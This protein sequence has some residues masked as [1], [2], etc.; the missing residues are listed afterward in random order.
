MKSYQAMLKSSMST[1]E[2]LPTHYRPTMR[3]SACFPVRYKKNKIDTIATLM[4]YWMLKRAIKEV[5]ILITIRTSDGEKILI[6]NEIVDS[7]KSYKWSAGELLPERYKITGEFLGSIEI[8]VFSSRDLVFPY[9]AITFCYAGTHGISFVHTCGRIYNDFDDIQDNSEQ[10]VPETGFDIIPHKEFKPFF[11][12]MNGPIPVKN[13]SIELCFINANGQT[14]NVSRKIE[15]VNPYGT[16][17]IDIFE[18]DKERDFLKE[19]PGS[20]KIS[21]NFQGFF[22]R[23]VAGNNFDNLSA[24]SLTHTYYDTTNDNA[25]TALWQNP[26]TKDF[27][28]S[29]MMLPINEYFDSI[30]FVVYPIFK[31]HPCTLHFD[32]FSNDGKFLFRSDEQ[33]IVA[34]GK[35]T[36][37]Y[38]DVLE[39]YKK[40][41]HNGNLALCRIVID[42]NGTTPTRM[43]F[44]LNFGKSS[45]KYKLDLPSNICESAKVPNSNILKK[46]GS[47]KWCPILDSKTQMVYITNTGFFK[48]DKLAAELKI[49]IWRENDNETLEW[50]EEIQWNGC[51]EIMAQNSSKLEHFL[52]GASGWITIKSNSPFINGYYINCNKKGLVGGDH[53]F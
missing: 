29:V 52:Q 18:N 1:G 39:M 5:T 24:V 22:P 20:I 51:N 33:H 4:G 7:V 8:E 3:A 2:T 19:R 26:N 14:L 42:G 44:G 15:D 21:H 9:P 36:V 16:A 40:S 46:S 50:I 13:E 6:H 12:F 49:N 23:F 35:K 47:F 37:Q 38:I 27:F 17:W 43:K 25:E 45:E 11:S 28:D 31:K 48:G 53:L 32:F 34:D 41:G 10:V 30:Q